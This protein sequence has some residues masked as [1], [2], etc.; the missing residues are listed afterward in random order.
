MADLDDSPH[1]NSSATTAAV[2]YVDIKLHGISNLPPSFLAD[3]GAAPMFADHPFRYAVDLS[4]G[5]SKA[6]LTNGRLL[7][8]LSMYDRFVSN[9]ALAPAALESIGGE[10]GRGGD[11]PSSVKAP[12]RPQASS[13]PATPVPAGDIGIP[14]LKPETPPPAGGASTAANSALLEEIAS[15]PVQL[16]WVLSAESDLAE[17]RENG[18]AAG[19]AKKD[20][21]GAAAKGKGAAAASPSTAELIKPVAPNFDSP[22]PTCIAR[23]LL[24]PQQVEQLEACL[25][26][27]LPLN[28]TFRRSLRVGCPADW[29]D[30]QEA[31]FSACI[32]VPLS[33]LKE[34]GTVTTTATVPLI[35]AV[36]DVPRDDDK[37]K[38]KAPVK[39]G[40]GSAPSIL[41]DEM[42][43]S[44]EHPYLANQT[45]AHVTVTFATALTRLPQSRPRP[46][47][48]PTD[49]IPTRLRAPKRPM[50]ATKTFAAEIESLTQRIVKEYREHVASSDNNTNHVDENISEVNGEELR[51][52]FLNYLQSS[53][54][55]HAYK[56]LLIPTVQ[57]V[58]KEK[59]VRQPNPSKEELNK[60]TNEL[61]TYL[62]DTMHA[63]IHRLFHTAEK[64]QRTTR[65]SLDGMS[66]SER[67]KRRAME[68]EVMREYGL[69]AK[70]HQ[71]RLGSVNPE[72]AGASNTSEDSLP[73]IWTEYAEF[74]LRVR[75]ALKAEQAYREALA[76]DYAHLPSLIGY[77]LLLLNSNRYQEAEVFLQSA[78]DLQ[79]NMLTWGCL[80]LLYDMKAL[81]LPDTP[82]SET[83]RLQF[84]RESKYS[85]TQATRPAAS[86]SSE[87]S[88]AAPT[89]ATASDAYLHISRHCVD[90][91]LEDLANLSLVRCTASDVVELLYATIYYQTE[92]YEDAV[93][94]LSK[95]VESNGSATAPRILYGDVLYA[96][97]QHAEAESMYNAA[98]RIDP[99]C[100]SGPSYVRLGNMC[101]SLGKYRDALAAF[102]SGAKVWP[103]GLT[104]LGVGISYYRMEDM[105]RAE[106]ALNQSNI[107][108]N[109]NPKT[110]AFIAL[111]C[112]RQRREDEADQAFNQA[113]KQGLDD[114]FLIAEV[115]VEQLR[116]GRARVAEMCFRRSITVADDVNTH[117]QLGRALCV[118]KRFAEAREEFQLVAATT[119]SDA[120]RAKAEEQLSTIPSTA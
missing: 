98:M 108:N 72:S 2:N 75:D 86:S 46:D 90:L 39:K 41:T 35:P 40:K 22:H 119:T 50:D 51:A 42:D 104:W 23:L 63:T 27:S 84:V 29:E 49:L 117:M 3:S 20:A 103:C 74:S 82:Q 26:Q 116:I 57:A 37:G 53:G 33:A 89:D 76:L 107:L 66:P 36:V 31:R 96:M 97:G 100:G 67:W 1:S 113:I 16:L 71:E 81:S 65:S 45:Q 52:S 106:Q 19:G 4:I 94:T 101:A 68:A 77:G 55:A 9:A 56:Q 61:Y 102:I 115:G 114:A 7:S 21:K 69:A 85:I 10:S 38:K 80:A 105:M 111:L 24:S 62:T 110:W 12:N 13:T 92:Q 58:V 118:M 25:E 78:V 11:V 93:A 17:A 30:L 8:H 91:Y 59:F 32:A 95:I 5:D 79:P 44:S 28:L 60:V 48:Q 14:G 18:E 109:L 99:F 73:N 120:Q 54:Q 70:Y 43:A 83:Q 34:P 6:S 112:L 87:G 64:Q 47:L 15:A 88:S